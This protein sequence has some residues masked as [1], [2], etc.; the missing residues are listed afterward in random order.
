MGKEK[1][2]WIVGDQMMDIV[3]ALPPPERQ[4]ATKVGDKQADESI[5]YELASDCAMAC[6]VCCEHDLVLLK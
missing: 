6:I 3:A 5:R 4:T 1:T 2:H